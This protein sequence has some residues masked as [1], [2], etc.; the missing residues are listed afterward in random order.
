MVLMGVDSR[1]PVHWMSALY[2]SLQKWHGPNNLVSLS[3]NKSKANF[4]H[5][6]FYH[7]QTVNKLQTWTNSL[8]QWIASTPPLDLYL[9]K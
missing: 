9:W 6:F 1:Q 3:D 5:Y 2:K 4:K 8:K 7:Y